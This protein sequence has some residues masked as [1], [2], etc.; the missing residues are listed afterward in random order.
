[1]DIL[2]IK[3]DTFA[4]AIHRNIQSLTWKESSKAYI[5]TEEDGSI[6]GVKKEQYIVQVL[7]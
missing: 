4:S 3:L 6:T 5:I 7:R 2:I 1:M